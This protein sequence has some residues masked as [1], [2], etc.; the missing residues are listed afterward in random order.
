GSGSD[1]FC[2]Q[3]ATFT[4]VTD[5]NGNVF[6]LATGT[7]TLGRTQPTP[8][9]SSDTSD[10]VSPL[11]ISHVGFYDYIGANGVTNQIKLCFSSFPIPTN[12]SQPGVMQAQGYFSPSLPGTPAMDLVATVVLPDHTKWTLNYDRYGEII[13]LGLPL[14]GSI[15][16]TWTE[17]ASQSCASGDE[18]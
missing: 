1:Y 8:P 10:C 11:A 18:T 2:G 9:T 16:Y 12:F 15:S 6:N 14:G 13:S 3:L 17:I 7:D 5:R 4:T